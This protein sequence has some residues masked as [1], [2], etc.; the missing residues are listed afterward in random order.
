MTR[1]GRARCRRRGAPRRASLAISLERGVGRPRWNSA[2]VKSCAGSTRSSRWWRTS[3]RSCSVGLAVPMSMPRYTCMGRS[4]RARPSAH[5]PGDAIATADFP[6][7][8]GPTTASHGD[9]GDRGQ[10]R[11]TS[12]R[13]DGDADL[14]RRLGEDSTKRPLEVVRRGAGD[15]DG[16]VAARAQ[17]RAARSARACSGGCGRWC[18]AGP[19]CSGPRRGPPRCDRRAPRGDERRRSTTTRRRSNRSP[20]TAGST[21]S[22]SSRRLGARPRARR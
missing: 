3:A 8:V 11:A 7:A 14:V 6:D 12:Q 21:K 15:L 19:S 17:R 13:G 22:A 1:G 10:S 5:L 20:A 16:G 18:T 4:T 9:A 2:T